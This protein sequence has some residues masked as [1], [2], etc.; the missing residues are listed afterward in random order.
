MVAGESGQGKSIVFSTTCESG[1]LELYGKTAYETL[2]SSKVQGRKVL[3]KLRRRFWGRFL[4]NKVL[5]VGLRQVWRGS[6]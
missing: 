4:D 2:L 5:W 6:R 3:G 1:L